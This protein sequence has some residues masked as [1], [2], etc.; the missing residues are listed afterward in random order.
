MAVLLPAR[1]SAAKDLV[2]TELRERLVGLAVTASRS[3]KGAGDEAADGNR[4]R[5]QRERKQRERAVHQAN[6]F[7]DA[8][9]AAADAHALAS[10][11][12]AAFQGAGQAQAPSNSPR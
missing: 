10:S 11:P 9:L 4:R 2:H 8:V 6:A 7:V 12:G 5:M 1:A 3:A